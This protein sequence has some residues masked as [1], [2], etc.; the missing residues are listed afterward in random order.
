MSQLLF[1]FLRAINTGGRRLT[2]DRLLAPFRDL[3]LDDVAAYQA[4]GNVAFRTDRSA[5]DLEA[6]LEDVL[7]AAYGF[8]VPVFV[9]SADELTRVVGDLPFTPADLAASQGKVQITF[10][11]S[12]PDPDRLAQALALVPAEDPR[13]VR[14]PGVALAA[15]C[16]SQ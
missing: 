7:A 14:R 16:G 13:R 8:D 15:A 1:A 3:G 2:N 5:D 10:M 4:A 11:R 12:A 9:R 6:D